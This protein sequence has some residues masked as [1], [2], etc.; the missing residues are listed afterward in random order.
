[1]QKPKSGRK[2]TKE[3]HEVHR[4][5]VIPQG[6]PHENVR[7]AHQGSEIPWLRI[8]LPKRRMQVSGTSEVSGQAQEETGGSTSAP[9]PHEQRGKSYKME[10]DNQGLD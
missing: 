2:D 4:E 6:E 9:E 5:E 8:L 1:M 10:P 7:S 3:Y